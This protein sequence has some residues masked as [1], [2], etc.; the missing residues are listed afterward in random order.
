VSEHFDPQAGAVFSADIAVPEHEREQRFYSRVLTTGAAPLWRDDLMNNLGIPIIGLG[1]RAPAH[2]ALPLQWMPHIQVADVK[3]STDRA[4]QR[5]GRVLMQSPEGA[6]GG[7]WAVLLDPAGAAFGIIPVPVDLPALPPSDAQDE[8]AAPGRIGWLDLTVPDAA[9]TRDF[10][11][12]VVG[13]GVQELE[14]TDGG[15]RYPD[16]VMLNAAGAP[17]AGICHARGTNLGLP[18]VWMIYVTVADVTASLEQVEA[19]GGSIIKSSKDKEGRHV[20][21][22]VKDP[23]GVAFALMPG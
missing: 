15:E 7:S 4:V 21:A 9:A 22:A 2:D 18:P 3:A 16:F 5:G 14:M 12:D 8:Q 6:P 10:Y 1:A 19:E 17:A 13:W 23:V 20:Y 11:R